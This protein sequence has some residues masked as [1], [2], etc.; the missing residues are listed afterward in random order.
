MTATLR[1]GGDGIRYARAGHAPRSGTVS[2]VGAKG[3]GMR[4]H[5]G[6]RTHPQARPRR[7]PFAPPAS[8]TI[9]P[10]RLP[11]SST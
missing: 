8:T 5:L 10:R 2:A 3:I 7:E 1:G 11:F 4:T 6:P 9:R